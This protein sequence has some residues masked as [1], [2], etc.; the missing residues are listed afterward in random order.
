MAARA[1]GTV[2]SPFQ[3][4]VFA[5]RFAENSNSSGLQHTIDFT[6]GRLDIEMVQNSIA[7][8]YVKAIV[9]KGKA[10]RLDRSERYVVPHPIEPCSTLGYGDVVFRDIHSPNLG[11]AMREMTANQAIA[12]ADFTDCF[13][14]QIRHIL[15][16][17]VRNGGRHV[18]IAQ[19]LVGNGRGIGVPVKKFTFALR[20]LHYLRWRSKGLRHIQHVCVTHRH[21]TCACRICSIAVSASWLN[22]RTVSRVYLWSIILLRNCGGM[23][24]ICAPASAALCT[25]IVLRMLPT[26]IRDG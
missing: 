3:Q 26:I 11:P 8:H 6:R 25:S 14:P 21:A 1:Q 23:V 16:D 2:A 10:L 12:A 17:F 4:A 20:P 15:S 24:T 7:E 5:Q 19:Q 18:G 13:A 22:C 9:G